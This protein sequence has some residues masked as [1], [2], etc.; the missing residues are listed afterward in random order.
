MTLLDCCPNA[1]DRVARLRRLYERRA[2]DEVFAFMKTPLRAMEDFARR[3]PGGPCA[4]PAPEERARF[5]RR[6]LAEQAR[7]DDDRVPAA[8]LTELDQGLYGGLVGAPVHFMANPDWG[9]ISS[10]VHPI[11]REWDEFDA[12]HFDPDGEWAKRYREIL[13]VHVAAASG[14]YG[15]SHFILIDSLNFVFELVGATRTYLA[16]DENPRRVRQAVDFAFDLNTWVQDRF[17]E[18]APLFAGGT[19]SNTA[20]W[21]PGRVVS[22]SV[23]PFHMT[24]AETFCRWGV[25]PVERILARYDGGITHIHG[26]GRHLLDAVC[27]LRGLRAVAFADDKGA[28]RAFDERHELRRRTGDMPLI[29][30]APWPD[31]IAALRA[32]SLAGGCLYV[33]GDVPDADSAHRA[34]EEVRRYRC[35]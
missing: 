27:R 11:L 8:Y 6:L 2:T 26:N 28:V 14:R 18:A 22:E 16:L 15:L 1:A 10:M 34:M 21:L 5:W 9:W 35:G 24:S 33:V 12:L 23:D 7:V 13:R 19:C 32:R 20:G 17:F 31:F 29:L 3:H 30:S 4:Y 25:E